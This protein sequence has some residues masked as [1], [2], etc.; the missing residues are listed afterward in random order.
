M[1]ADL[2]ERR[3]VRGETLRQKSSERGRVRMMSKML[4]RV[5]SSEQG[6]GPV[7]SAG[8]ILCQTINTINTNTTVS[9]NHYIACNDCILFVLISTV[10]WRS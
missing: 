6:P 9:Y 1:M 8:N 7:G 2:E 10:R 5:S 4:N 3:E